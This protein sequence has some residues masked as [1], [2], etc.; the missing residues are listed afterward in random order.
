M[1]TTLE[2]LRILECNR[3]HFDWTLQPDDS[4]HTERRAKPRFHI[5]ARLRDAPR[6][7]FG[8]LQAVCYLRTGAI[9]GND[10]WI[11]AAGAIEMDLPE[12]AT[13]VAAADDRTWAGPKGKRVPVEHLV[14]MRRRLLEAVGLIGRQTSRQQIE[15][16]LERGV[17]EPRY[18]LPT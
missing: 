3:D 9:V 4:P 14:A 1:L 15:D 17:E 5:Q 6:S 8:P 18:E 7:R 13:L 12:A 10:G 16:I 2:F 11:Q